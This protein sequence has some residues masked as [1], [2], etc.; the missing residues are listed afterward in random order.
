M[1]RILST[2]LFYLMVVVVF[3]QGNCPTP[4]CL[5]PNLVTNPGF[6]V[7]TDCNQA[8]CGCSMGTT[9]GWG[10]ATSGTADAFNSCNHA[11]GGIGI[12]S[13]GVPLNSAGYQYPHSGNGYAGIITYDAGSSS[14]NY[15]EYIQT[16][17]SQP[18]VPGQA[19]YLEFFVS[20]GDF[21]TYAT[22]NLGVYF[23][24]VTT[25]YSFS[26]PYPATPTLNEPTVIFDTANWV[27][28]CWRFVATKPFRSMTIGNF[29]NDSQTTKIYSSSVGNPFI[30]PSGAY[31]Y[32][33]DV[34]LATVFDSASVEASEWPP[35]ICNNDSALVCVTPGFASYQWNNGS[36]S[37]CFHTSLAGNYYVTVTDSTGC[38]VSSNQVAVSVYPPPLVSVSVIG[39]AFVVYNALSCQWYLNGNVINGAIDS[40]YV[41][42]V[43]GSYAVEVTDSNGCSAFSLPLLY[44]SVNTEHKPISLGIYPNPSSSDFLITI[45]AGSDEVFLTVSDVMG[46][47]VRKANF[48]NTAADEKQS[49]FVVP[50]NDLA[51]G[52]YLILVAD[53]DGNTSSKKLLKD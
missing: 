7:Y 42:D 6:E 10:C 37:T 13:L 11:G 8:C 52:I 17:F 26:I 3:A 23:D 20:N 33:D 46:R 44:S 53:K 31:Y 48:S 1:D 21:S 27:K 28:V 34:M 16:R 41:P 14:N 22:N 32:I 35:V 43:A 25:I 15:R 24:T 39:N 50:I 45:L 36:T 40:V 2:I 12:A 5:G 49:Q 9:P 29:Y 18:L 47:I 4:T 30:F 38:S 51:P 19:Y